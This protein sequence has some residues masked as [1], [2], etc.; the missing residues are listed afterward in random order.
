MS[1]ELFCSIC[2]GAFVTAFSINDF[3]SVTVIDFDKP[4]DSGLRLVDRAYSACML[5]SVDIDVLNLASR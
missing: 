3:R 4:P 5:S 2:G 1:G